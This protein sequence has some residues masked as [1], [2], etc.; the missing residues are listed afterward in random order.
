MIFGSAA[1][2]TINLGDLE[3]GQGILLGDAPGDLTGWSVA[4]AGDVN[5][6]GFDDLI[7]GAPYGSEGGDYAGQAYLIF[8]GKAL[9]DIDL[10]SLGSSQG[11]V[12][13]GWCRG[14]IMPE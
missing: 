14:A 6:D 9:S 7:I 8:G 11:I 5:G 3:A 13:R 4:L 12:H 10:K 2:E 1:A